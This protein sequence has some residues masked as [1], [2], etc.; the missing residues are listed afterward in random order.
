ME[1]YLRCEK[2]H[3]GR[4]CVVKLG[5]VGWDLIFC[6]L[7]KKITG[8]PPSSVCVFISGTARAEIRLSDTILSNFPIAHWLV[9]S[10]SFGAQRPI[11]IRNNGSL[12]ET[13]QL[14]IVERLRRS[15]SRTSSLSP[16]T[17]HTHIHTLINMLKT[18]PSVVMKIGVKRHFVTF[19]T[20]V[21]P[22]NRDR[23]ESG[24]DGW[25]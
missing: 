7:K 23:R 4:F 19:R 25:I 17:T 1:R 2:H 22:I 5:M 11:S 16:W 18:C 12:A 14:I 3:L 24:V 13:S 10:F 6:K 21:R 8:L 15:A 20:G 9:S